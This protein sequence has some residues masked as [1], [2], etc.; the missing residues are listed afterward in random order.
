MKKIITKNILNII[1]N[2]VVTDIPYVW[3]INTKQIAEINSTKKYCELIFLLQLLH[4][5]FK[6]INDKNGILSCHFIL[7]LH[8]GQ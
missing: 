4:F 2:S 8:D 5:P 3:Y 7:L 6:N 1:S